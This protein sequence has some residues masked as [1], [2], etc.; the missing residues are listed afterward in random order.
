MT[1]VRLA[2]WVGTILLAVSFCTA[3]K[4]PLIN[5][6][7]GGYR[8]QLRVHHILGWL[9]ISAM[10]VHL[11]ALL[12][13]YSATLDLL[14]NLLDPAVITGWVA[15]AISATIVALAASFRNAPY[16][17]WRRAHLI[18]ILA[19]AFG[20]AHSFL[21]LE[22]RTLSEWALIGAVTF[23]GVIGIFMTVC[24]PRFSS[25]GI[26]Y[27]I[28]QQ[29][30]LRNDLFWQTLEPAEHNQTISC[31]AGQFFYV[32]FCGQKFSKAWHPFTIISLSHSGTCELLIKSRGYDTGILHYITLPCFVKMKGPF[33]VKFWQSDK[34]QLW[35]A[36]G[37]GI[38]I[39][40]A[41]S[42]TFP[43]W[44]DS[45]VHLVYGEKSPESVLFRNE[46]DALSNIRDNFSWEE[47]LG[48][49]R[50][51]L[52]ALQGNIKKEWSHD[53]Q[54]FRI[55]GHPN[56]QIAAKNL[57]LKVG[58]ARSKIILEGVF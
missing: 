36:Y 26:P 9:A 11:G 49:G 8:Q 28:V 47:S 27:K 22:P 50:K 32:R 13:D 53:Y 54:Q 39:F 55:C 40:L 41:A 38:A 6:L 57:L 37:V 51:V 14:G 42:R 7:V 31:K 2:G 44:F 15:F 52:A 20:I 34:S 1:L 46:L 10:M 19:F 30:Q 16:R 29:T 25:I 35:I 3:I 17:R 58:V 5:F 56:F 23:A 4:S 45:K 24:L 21:V 48:D 12:F 18:L 33:G 43:N